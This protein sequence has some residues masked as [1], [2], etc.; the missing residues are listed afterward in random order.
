MSRTIPRRLEGYKVAF[1]IRKLRETM[2]K[3][4]AKD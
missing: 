4:T 2:D 1:E 3:T